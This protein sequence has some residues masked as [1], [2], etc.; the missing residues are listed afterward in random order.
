VHRFDETAEQLTEWAVEWVRDRLALDPVPLDQRA[1][2]AE[3]DALA[4]NLIREAPRQPR[5]VI[6]QYTE[7]LAPRVLSSDSPRFL[8]FIPSAPTKASCLFDMVVSAS[9]LNGT[10]WLEAAGAIH[11]ENQ[12]LAVLAELA[13]LPPAAG[14][15][16]VSGGSA[17]NL[18]AL[19][20]ARDVARH[21]RGDRARMAIV[22][23]E[24][25]HSSVTSTANLLDCDLIDVPAPGGRLNG[26][27]VAAVAAGLDDPTL[28]CAVVATAGTT[29]AGIV[30]DL[31]GV[32]EVARRYDWWFHVD[33]AYGGAGLLS[34]MVRDRFVGIEHADSFVVDPHK[35]LFS[36]LDCCAL[37]YRNPQLAKGVHTQDAS[38]LDAIREASDEWNPTDYAYHL[39][40]RARGLATWFSLAVNGISAYRDAVDQAIVHARWAAERIGRSPEL[41]LVHDPDLSIV[42]FRRRGWGIADYRRWSDDLLERGVGFVLPSS[43]EGEPVLRLAILHPDTD[44]LILEEILSSLES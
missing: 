8:S 33:G 1:T 17:G 12:V 6:E 24:Q 37:L 10:S 40:R 41:E 9:A 15:C 16:F 39:S 22:C 19:A 18:S 43:W 35:W 13:G 36:P 3:L 20:V 26:D 5:E 44:E 21:R 32:S 30:D 2:K 34:R 14:G 31:A 28:V 38:Y 7:I 11:A 23:S 42:M 4:P 25:V 29:N 27:S